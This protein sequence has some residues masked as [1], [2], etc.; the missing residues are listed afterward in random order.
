MGT[1]G[2]YGRLRTR[3]AGGRGCRA[4]L[5]AVVIS[6]CLLPV[7]AGCSSHASWSSGSNQPVAVA[8]PPNQPAY[9]SAAQ[10][11]TAQVAPS[12]YDAPDVLP[13]PKQSLVDLLKQD[14]AAA[15][16]QP[17]L[18]PSPAGTPVTTSSAAA[19][20]MPYPKQS[21]F[22][23]FQDSGKTPAPAQAQ[24]MPH[25]PSTYTPSGQPYVP[26]QGQPTYSSATAQ[27]AQRP[28]SAYTPSG[29]P[30][31]PPGQPAARPPRTPQAAADDDEQSVP[32]YPT[33]SIFDVSH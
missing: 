9:S 7:I 2:F 13:Y 3:R 6:F 31:P 33:R 28:P 14:A 20:A 32:G 4:P 25:P 1:Q 12:D 16:A 5:H 26:P 17:K 15:A 19:D 22:S 18:P 11:P 30:Y 27:S 10:P 8:P 29:Q 24:D 23:L 21:L